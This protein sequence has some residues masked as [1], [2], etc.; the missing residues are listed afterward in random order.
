M[1]FASLGTSEIEK[2]DFWLQ[3][4][5]N[6]ELLGDAGETEA[7]HQ[8]VDY[9]QRADKL[10]WDPAAIG[11]RIALIASKLAERGE[12]AAAERYFDIGKRIAHDRVD[13]MHRTFGPSFVKGAI[14]SGDCDKAE[15]YGE[16]FGLEPEKYYYLMCRTLVDDERYSEAV[17][18]AQKYAEVGAQT[19][20]KLATFG[21]LYLLIRASI[22][23]LTGEDQLG[24]CFTGE[25]H[26]PAHVPRAKLEAWKQL[27]DWYID[28]Q[29]ELSEQEH[30]ELDKSYTKTSVRIVLEGHL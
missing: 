21:Q 27:S 17:K 16:E 2:R 18:W 30:E 13:Q 11:Y 26:V 7:Y 3:K 22:E 29:R 24:T 9:Y 20:G 12:L 5:E 1:G 15:S 28:W 8:A 19:Y 14:L 6:A 25:I 10:R 4:A 23:G